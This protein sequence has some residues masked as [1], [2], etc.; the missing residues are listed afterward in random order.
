MMSL[1]TLP[2]SSCGNATVLVTMLAYCCSCVVYCWSCVSSCCACLAY[3]SNC[4]HVVEQFTQVTA[5]CACAGRGVA[6]ATVVR[7][8]VPQTKVMRRAAP[9]RLLQRFIVHPL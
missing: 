9:G 8:A 2:Q 1:C 7:R 5:H 4:V 6:T 3:S